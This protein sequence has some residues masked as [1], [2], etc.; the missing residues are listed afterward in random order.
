VW[1]DVLALRIAAPIVPACS[2][3]GD[4]RNFEEYSEELPETANLPLDPFQHY[5]VV[6][7][8]LLR[9]FRPFMI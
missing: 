5:F 2:G 6:I 9:D 3:P 1:E 4:T 8:F 7:L